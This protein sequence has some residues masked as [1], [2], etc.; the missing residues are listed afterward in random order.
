MKVIVHSFYG[1]ISQIDAIYQASAQH[2][3]GLRLPVLLS[4][5]ERPKDNALTIG[6]SHSRTCDNPQDVIVSCAAKIWRR[7]LSSAQIA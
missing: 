3:Y 2:G 4:H 5:A 1:L 6:K 7:T